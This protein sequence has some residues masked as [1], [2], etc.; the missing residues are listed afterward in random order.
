MNETDRR[1]V[2]R[3]AGLAVTA[4]AIGDPLA[5]SQPQVQASKA[6]RRQAELPN[7]LTRKLARF[8][9]SAHLADMP[10]AVRHE[11]KRTLLNWVG[12]ALGGSQHE[13]V[14][15]AVA[16]L[17]GF[18]GARQATLFGRPERPDALHAALL[19]GISSH[20]LDFDD[21]HTQ[22]TIHPP[23]P[24]A[25]A[26]F[27]L[28]EYQQVS[29]RDFIEALVVG[30]EAECRIGKAAVPAH[31][32]SGWHITGTAGVFGSAAAAGKL[33]GPNARP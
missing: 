3:T 13:T 9:I 16:A 33:L 18:F 5:N 21:T 26:I 14:A 6:A 22:T 1:D 24:L 19:N 25:P 2:L 7:D 4:A 8:V 23:A 32:D 28:A 20:V 11:A 27:A 31:Y 12:C 10:E 30:V 17:S 15:N 29:G